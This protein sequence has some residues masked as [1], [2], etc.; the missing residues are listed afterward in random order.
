MRLTSRRRAGRPRR[1]EQ[2]PRPARPGFVL[3]AA[4]LALVVVGALAAGLLF[5]A[6]Q[7]LRA[8]GQGLAGERALAAAE[9]ALADASALWAGAGAAPP[10][11]SVR[12]RAYAFEGGD[13]AALR[14]TSVTAA[15]VWGSAVG[16]SGAAHGRA[17]RAVSMLFAVTA[18][19]DGVPV[20][21]P[22]TQRAWLQMF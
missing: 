14:L 19:P 18:G 1:A 13:A 7:Q 11:G 9:R 16:E 2:P 12:E 17:R 22:V 4:L 10:V 3:A 20:L 21:A 15:T 5:S 8:G 6:T